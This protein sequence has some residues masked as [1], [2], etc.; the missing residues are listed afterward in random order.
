MDTA[1]RWLA[2]IRRCLALAGLL[3]LAYTVI[4]ISWLFGIKLPK[5]PAHRLP[6]TLFGILWRWLK[7][8]R[9]RILPAGVLMLVVMAASAGSTM[10]GGVSVIVSPSTLEISPSNS[11]EYTIKLSANPVGLDGV[12]CGDTV[13]VGVSGGYFLH[14]FDLEPQSFY[15]S[16]GTDDGNGNCEGGDWDTEK[17]VTAT[18]DSDPEGNASVG[19]GYVVRKGLKTIVKGAGSLR[20]RVSG[21]VPRPPTPTPTLRPPDPPQDKQ[22]AA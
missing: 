21:V 14:Y 16:T 5:V 12:E 6:Q 1:R 9:L 4:L 8:N 20:I 2:G 10:G 13:S 7:G 17:T 11:G 3:L 18:V 19:V 22:P 15:F